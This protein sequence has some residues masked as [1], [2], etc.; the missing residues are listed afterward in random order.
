MTIKTGGNQVI[1]PDTQIGWMTKAEFADQ[2]AYKLP[3]QSLDLRGVEG[4]PD[5]LVLGL[6]PQ[7]GQNDYLYVVSRQRF[8]DWMQNQLQQLEGC[9]S[10]EG[11][12][13]P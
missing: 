13:D 2:S 8:V 12:I 6:R 11:E 5:I 4:R 9:T 1:D 3:L 10:P 7:G